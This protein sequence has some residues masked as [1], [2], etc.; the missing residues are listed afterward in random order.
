MGVQKGRFRGPKQPFWHPKTASNTPIMNLRKVLNFSTVLGVT[1][2]GEFTNAIG[3]KKGDYVEV[4]LRDK[5]TI[6]IKPHRVE[7]KKLTTN[8]K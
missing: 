4:Y 8:D 2:P 6:V 3:V 5:K 1:L 7:P